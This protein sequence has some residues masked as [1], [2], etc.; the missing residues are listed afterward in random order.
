MTAPTC[1]TSWPTPRGTA[2]EVANLNYW[3]YWI[4]ESADDQ[5]GDEFMAYDDPN[6]WV[7]AHLLHHLTNRLEPASRHL[8]LNLHTVHALVA[9]RPMLLTGWP[10]ARAAL[11]EALERIAS[12]D[13]LTRTGR[14]QVAGLRYALRIAN[15]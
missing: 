14:D 10:A 5:V 7:G 1:T 6:Q 2:A 3:A 13:A 8:P 12:S 4:G 9:S 15:R 11:A